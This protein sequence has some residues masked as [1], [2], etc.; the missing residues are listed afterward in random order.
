MQAGS[1]LAGYLVREPVEYPW[2]SISPEQ[3]M[4]G[5]TIPPNTNV[6]FHLPETG[7]RRIAR[8]TL[9]GLRGKK[10]RYWGYC[11]PANYDPQ[12]VDKRR[13]FPGLIFLSE[14][15]RIARAEAMRKR[16]P[17]FSI[18]VLP[19]ADD[20]ARISQ[21]NPF[22]IR[23]QLELFDPATMCFIMTEEALAIGLD[24]DNDRL[25][26]Q[27]ERELSTNRH[28]PDSDGDGVSDGIEH[29]YNTVPTVRDTDGDGLID[30]IEDANWNGRIDSG[31]TDPR[32]RDSDRDGLCDGMCR[33]RLKRQ[34]VFMGED[35][36]LN[37]EVDA[38]ETDPSKWSTGENGISD[39]IQFLRCIA[40]GRAVCP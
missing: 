33:V 27:L 18:N 32:S 25:N 24:P 37:G 4:S 3:V 13:G 19:S 12:N 35:K 22:P 14:K 5:A 16:K 39:E 2:V 34:D 17:R 9:F 1:S 11:F 38:G 6:V 31:E 28:I 40:E 30:G 10:V 26:D 21:R 15:E 20:I 8:E 29:L 23:H 7:F 36:N